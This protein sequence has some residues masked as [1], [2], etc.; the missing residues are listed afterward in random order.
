MPLRREPPEGPVLR[1]AEGKPLK[2]EQEGWKGCSELSH[3]H[4]AGARS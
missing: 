4:A 1:E 3:A 2:T